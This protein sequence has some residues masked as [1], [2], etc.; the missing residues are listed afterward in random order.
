ML[1][2]VNLLTIGISSFNSKLQVPADIAEHNQYIDKQN[3]QTQQYLTNINQW[4]KE[5][6]DANK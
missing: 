5:K 6:K 2:I 4:T 3:L 1:E